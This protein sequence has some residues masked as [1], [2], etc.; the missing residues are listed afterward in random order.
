M[1]LT[2]AERA[3]RYREKNKEEVKERDKLRKKHQRELLKT[4]G[5]YTF[6]KK[7]F[8]NF[9]LTFHL[10]YATIFRLRLKKVMFFFPDHDQ[11]KYEKI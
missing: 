8:P 2:S 4:Q 1:P 3:K 11:P 10:Q 6:S 7:V 5:S 9:P